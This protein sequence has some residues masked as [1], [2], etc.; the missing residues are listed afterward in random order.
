MT[1]SLDRSPI[2]MTM[3]PRPLPGGTRT[4][5]LKVSSTSLHL[6]LYSFLDI[7]EKNKFSILDVFTWVSLDY[8]Y[9]GSKGRQFDSILFN[10]TTLENNTMLL[11]T[12]STYPSDKITFTLADLPRDKTLTFLNI[13]LHLNEQFDVALILE[14]SKRKELSGSPKK[15]L[16]K[17]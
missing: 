15:I 11:P 16:Q 2:R 9:T 3:T 8:W 4:V 1:C 13:Y 6:E 7:L 12:R 17:L 10:L 14:D 5:L